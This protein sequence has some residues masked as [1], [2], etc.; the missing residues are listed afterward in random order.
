MNLATMN[1]SFTIDCF[2]DTQG[3]ALH[4][5]MEPLLANSKFAIPAD[6]VRHLKHRLKDYDEFHLVYALLMI[7]K[8]NVAEIL[9]ELVSALLLDS[10]AVFCAA[11]NTLRDLPAELITTELVDSLA[12]I[13]VRHERASLVATL[14]K[15]LESGTSLQQRTKR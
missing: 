7:A 14:V 4:D 8:A 13:H 3:N 9:S 6:A 15:D 5:L 1:R 11:L 2:E 12:R 10:D